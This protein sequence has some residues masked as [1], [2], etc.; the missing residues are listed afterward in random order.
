[1]TF[2][3]KDALKVTY[4]HHILG[5]FLDNAHD[6]R[7]E[8]NPVLFT[9]WHEHSFWQIND[10]RTL[11]PKDLTDLVIGWKDNRLQLVKNVS[12]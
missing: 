7:V 5:Y 11:S 3:D 12:E 8:G 10:D 6:K 2:T 4:G 1:M 9:N